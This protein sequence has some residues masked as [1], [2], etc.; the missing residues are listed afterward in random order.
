[1]KYRK[2]RIA[3]SVTCGIACVLLVVLW[4]RSY[5]WA[6]VANPLMTSRVPSMQNGTL[7]YNDIQVR[8]NRFEPD[9]ILSRYL[10]RWISFSYNGFTIRGIGASIPPW[11]IIPPLVILASFP[12]IRWRFSLRTLLI[13]TTIIGLIL[14]LIIAT[15]R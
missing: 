15:T 5:W 12:W 13:A 8:P 9:P 6:D 10:P 14:G 11:A 2:M 3:V 1:M 4:V 7:V